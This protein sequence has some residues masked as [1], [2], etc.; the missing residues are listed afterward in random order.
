MP[1]QEEIREALKSLTPKAAVS[2][3]R[4]KIIS[5]DENNYTAEAITLLAGT[6]RSNVLLRAVD[7]SGQ[8]GFA[9]IPENDSEV[10]LG[11][12]ENVPAATFLVQASKVKKIVYIG[13]TN[14]L[15][16]RTA[17]VQQ[18]NDLKQAMNDLKQVIA[19]WTPVAQD[20]G[21]ALKAALSPWAAQIMQNTTDNDIKT[22]EITW[23]GS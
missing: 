6:E 10:L 3:I 16:D 7:A 12:I 23:T 9:V 2:V 4:A 8:F 14:G 19:A 17:L 11:V 5:V 13:S 21:A 1:Y 22:E 18:I 15:V 20:G